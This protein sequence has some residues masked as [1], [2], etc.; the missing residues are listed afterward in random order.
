MH[1]YSFNVGDYYSH[2]RGLTLLQDIAYRRL[3]DMLYLTEKPLSLNPT[4]LARRIDMRDH[5]EDVELVC[6]E[7]FTRTEEGWV[8]VREI[9]RAHV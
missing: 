2:T 1:Y 4:H 3:L 9:G 6:Q 5:V 7:Y 8:Q